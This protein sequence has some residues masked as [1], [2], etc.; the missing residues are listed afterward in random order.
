LASNSLLEALAIAYHAGNHPEN[1]EDVKFPIIP[2]WRDQGQ[3]NENEW[4]VISNNREI[5]GTIMQDYVGIRRSRRL[6]KYALS[7]LDNIYHEI[8]NFYEHNTVRKE[9][10][11]TRNMAVIAR[12]VIRSALTRKESRGAHYVIDYP[13]RDDTKYKIDTII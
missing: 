7:K 2:E 5:I 8:N 10:I 13:Y 1:L 6:L 3:F 12:M 9:V 11:E 4:I